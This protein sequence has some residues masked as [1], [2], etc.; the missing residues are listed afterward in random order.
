MCVPLGARISA[1]SPNDDTNPSQRQQKVFG[2]VQNL[3]TISPKQ[4]KKGQWAPIDG[5][6]WGHMPP[7]LQRCYMGGAGGSPPLILFTPHYIR[8]PFLFLFLFGDANVQCAMCIFSPVHCHHPY[9]Q[10]TATAEINLPR[11]IGQYTPFSSPQRTM[12]QV[13]SA[14]RQ[15]RGADEAG[16]AVCSYSYTKSQCHAIGRLWMV[17]HP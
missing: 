15:T 16:A 2:K 12:V 17:A 5:A 8:L 11:D 10:A 4:L 7:T 1:L 9:C 3:A 6:N 14:L 13:P